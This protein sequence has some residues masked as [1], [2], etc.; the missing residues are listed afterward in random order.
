MSGRTTTPPSLD[1]QLPS[2]SRTTIYDPSYPSPPA[3]DSDVIEEKDV[4]NVE[5]NY[6]ETEV[7]DFGNKLFVKIA[8]PYVTSYLYNRSFLDKEFGIRKDA[9]GQF[10]IG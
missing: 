4:G 2:T 1:T 8:R 9:D 3:E 5:D 10:R 7:Q 6:V